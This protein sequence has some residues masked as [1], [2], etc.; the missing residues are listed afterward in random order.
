MPKALKKEELKNWALDAGILLTVTI[1][2]AWFFIENEAFEFWYEYT[3]DHEDW[4][5]DE[6]SMVIIAN[7]FAWTL[8]AIRHIFMLR[9]T[10]RR[11]ERAKKTIE[12]QREKEVRSQKLSALGELATGLAHE[13]N[14]AMQPIVGLGPVL[15]K[16][17]EKSGNVKQYEYITL[18][19][20][21]GLHARNIVRS[22]LE[23][24]G[25]QS[26]HERMQLDA[27][28]NLL[29]AIGFAQSMLPTSITFEL[30]GLEESA[31]NLT[32]G[33]SIYTT[34]SELSQIFINLF[35]N[36]RDAMNEKGHLS[37]TVDPGFVA[38]AQTGLDDPESSPDRKY[39]ALHITD[40]GKGMD[41]ETLEK[42]FDPFFSTKDPSEGTGLG[43]SIVYGLVQQLGGTI[44]V[45]SEIGKGTTFT[46]VL[47]VIPSNIDNASEQKIP[48]RS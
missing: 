22:V 30:N 14:N 21:G 8:L 16:E 28:D 26:E 23:F 5:L 19:E 1:L 48:K 10:I 39:I 4:E 29:E 34:K 12:A 41:Q 2:L 42:V 3:R 17:L 6:W 18:I 31:L 44:K 40:T 13:I 43:T 47:P 45:E 37:V 20:Q 33:F 46:L 15:K 9:H 24:S 25:D 27:T 11:L 36:A 38:Q 35:N 7:L 32:D